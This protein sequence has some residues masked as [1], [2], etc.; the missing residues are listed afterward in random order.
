[1]S[2]EIEFRGYDPDTERWYYG[3]YVRLERTTPYPMSQNPE[4]DTL[5][6]EAEQ[7]DHYIFFT[8]SMD[9]GLET[10][11]LRA[12]VDPKSVGQYIGLKDKTGKR[13]Y[14]GDIVATT[15]GN[16]TFKSVVRFGWALDAEQYGSSYGWYT[17]SLDTDEKQTISKLNVEWSDEHTVVGTTYVTQ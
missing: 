12:T 8:E 4:L 2:R 15:Y 6:F 5:K 1:V 7:V 9:W 17:D 10:R 3:S 16:N 14:E 11:K 13:I